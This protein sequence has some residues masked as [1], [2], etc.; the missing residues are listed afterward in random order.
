M[1]A[2]LDS[3]FFEVWTSLT[4]LY[5][6]VPSILQSRDTFLCQA[7]KMM[8]PKTHHLMG[9]VRNVVQTRED[10]AHQVLSV[11]TL[12]SLSLT[13]WNTLLCKWKGHCC[14]E[15]L[16]PE[17]T[18]TYFSSRSCTFLNSLL[19]SKIGNWSLQTII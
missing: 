5:L 4:S 2:L 1:S 14:G 9:V 16:N 7:Q 12:M 17:S 11:L 15:N 6:R 19:K 3:K 18:V 8:C 13:Q 10:L